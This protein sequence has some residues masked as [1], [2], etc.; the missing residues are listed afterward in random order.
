MVRAQDHGLCGKTDEFL[1]QT[2]AAMGR[3]LLTNDDDFLVLD[4]SWQAAQRVHAG[5]VY[6]HQDKYAV[7]EAIRRIFDYVSQ[8]PLS[9]AANTAHYL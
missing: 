4:A 5:I 3:I 8:T 9:Q 1:L 2:A 7:G 6:W